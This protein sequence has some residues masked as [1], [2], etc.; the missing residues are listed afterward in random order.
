[1]KPFAIGTIVVAA[2]SFVVPIDVSAAGDPVA[3]KPA[4]ETQC[5]ACHTTAVGKNG[6]GPSL[7]QVIGRKSGGLAGFTAPPAKAQGGLTGDEKTLDHFLTSS[8]VAVPG[9]AMA[10]QVATPA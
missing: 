10:V 6:F 7:A 2:V 1:M 8:T 4:F 3:G 9:T 5:A